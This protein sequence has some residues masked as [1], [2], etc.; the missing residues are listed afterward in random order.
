MTTLLIDADIIVYR[1]ACAV[2]TKTDW[3]D[4]EVTYDANYSMGV[5]YLEDHIDDLVVKFPGADM[6]FCF[7]SKNNFRNHIYPSYKHNRKDSHR[8]LLLKKLREYIE[9]RYA[10]ESWKYL[11][12]DDVLGIMATTPDGEDGIEGERI[13]VTI[14][15]D[16]Y[17]I[18]VDVYNFV[19]DETSYA[20]ERDGFRLHMMQTLTGDSVDGYPGCPGVGQ[21]GAVDILNSPHKMES[22]EHTFVR[23]RREGATEIRWRQGDPCTIW[24]AIVS[25]F[26]QKGLTEEDALIQA[27]LAKILQYDDY[28]NKQIKLWEPITNE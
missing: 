23:G 8:P 22:Y 13:I 9:E 3:G 15:K 11:E 26:E 2:E 16:L 10:C 12:A 1:A 6:V 5:A 4:G 25:R 27:R 7:S 20:D 19:T 17:Q 18:P 14:D 24:E 21:K 28:P